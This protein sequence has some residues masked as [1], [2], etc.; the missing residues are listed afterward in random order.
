MRALVSGAAGF[1]GLALAERL[2]EAGA[3]QVLCVDNFVRGE[4]DDAFRALCQ[5]PNV[6]FLE[7]DL[8]A[9]D[10]ARRLPREPVDV[11]YH[12][13]ALNGTQN[14]YER[15]WEVLRCS[16]LPTFAL[17]EAYAT[18]PGL[19]RFVYAGSSE[20]YASTVTRFGWQVPTAEDVPL[21]IEDPL[22][23]RWSYG[24]S[25]LH[26]EVAVAQGCRQHGTPFTVIRYHNVYGPRMGDRHVVP[27]FI[28]RMRRGVYELHG[29]EDTR[30]FLYVDDA[31]RA[32][33]ALAECAGARDQIVNVGSDEELSILD[34]GRRLLATIGIE[35]E[36]ALH[37][38]PAGSVRRR[39]PDVTK[40]R[41]LVGFTPAV[42]LEEGLRR[43]VEFYWPTPDRA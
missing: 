23:A 12:L 26:G 43:T 1:L 19:S 32:T 21:C 27:D 8:A 28:E 33:I 4:R 3:E 18:R 37:P 16:T 10:A 31:V 22:N 2:A 36:I 42:A 6:T 13:A 35:A 14:F 9:P 20:S 38:S 39:A 41:E 29:W 24:V 7:L 5:R 11:V 17:L 30:S 25:K 15:P 40:L 34:L